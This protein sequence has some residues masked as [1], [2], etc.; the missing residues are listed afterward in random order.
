MWLRRSSKSGCRQ[1]ST[2][3]I[4]SGSLI[5]ELHIVHLFIYDSSVLTMKTPSPVLKVAVLPSA[6]GAGD[7]DNPSADGECLVRPLLWRRW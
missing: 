5:G 7:G 2:G 4:S 6:W 1:V 3:F